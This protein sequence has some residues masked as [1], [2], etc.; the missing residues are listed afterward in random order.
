[1]VQIKDRR[2]VAVGTGRLAALF[3]HLA[4]GYTSIIMEAQFNKLQVRP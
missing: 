4:C 2:M 3:R 1:M